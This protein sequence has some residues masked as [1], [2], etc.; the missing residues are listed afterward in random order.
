M[1]TN[2]SIAI[3][4]F[5]GTLIKGDSLWP[6]LG[7]T[8]GWPQTVITM[9]EAITH[10]LVQRWKNPNH[11]ITT[12]SRTFIKTYI[13]ENLLVDISVEKLSSSLENLYRWQ[14]WNIKIKNALL[15]HHNKGHHI[16]IASG[17]L[18]IYLPHL[19]KDIPYDA[20]ICTEIEVVDGIITGQMTSG[21]CVRARKAELVAGYLKTHGPYQDSWGYGN[22]PHDLPMLELVKHR[23]I[24]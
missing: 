22:T 16:V 21:N 18:N 13:L 17:G 4:D 20:L 8:A 2:S 6:F 9:G 11:D 19:L 15:D 3:F 24:V 1:S 5:D 14:K 23:I 12:D 7:F 10:N